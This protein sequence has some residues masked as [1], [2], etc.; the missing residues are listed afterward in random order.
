M[1]SFKFFIEVLIVF[2][3]WWRILFFLFFLKDI[4]FVEVFRDRIFY[5]RKIL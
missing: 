3:K 1:R 5:D 2:L 4:V